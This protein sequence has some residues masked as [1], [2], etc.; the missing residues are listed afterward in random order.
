MKNLKYRFVIIILLIMTGSVAS[1]QSAK[2]TKLNPQD[3]PEGRRNFGM[4]ALTDGKVLVFGGD[5]GKGH[6][7]GDT[8]IYDLNKG[9]WEKLNC[10]LQPSPRKGIAMASVGLNKV[11][12]FGGS[13]N[14]LQFYDDTW[15]FDYDSLNWINLNPGNKPKARDGYAMS[16]YKDG[17][18]ALYGG[19]DTAQAFPQDTW[20]YSL[21]ANN[22][23]RLS[24]GFDVD[25]A[26]QLAKVTDGLLMQFSGY[27]C[28]INTLRKTWLFDTLQNKW[29]EIFPKNSPP[30]ITSG[31]V[32]QLEDGKVVLFGGHS[33]VD[34]DETWLFDIK[35]SSWTQILTSV[36][37]Q[38]RYL[39]RIAKIGEGKILLFSGFADW[40]LTNDTWL[41]S[42]E[43]AGVGENAENSEISI[44]PNP[45]SNFIEITYSPSNK[46][47]L[48]GV[49]EAARIYNVFGEEINLTPT[50]SSRG[51]GVRIDVSSLP[52]GLYF[53][54]VGDKIGKFVKLSIN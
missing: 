13:T 10:P 48:G 35:D 15:I 19:N 47:G 7:L 23:Q 1:A 5:D 20:I 18:I 38:G 3:S 6:V 17:M 24:F 41:L 25:N 51:E 36:K 4:A 42:F 43:P 28:C 21:A 37:P 29:K 12:M 30:P 50:L 2:W 11:I 49:L 16:P 34:V 54:R 46:R 9:N 44:S 22:W 33:D 14:D 52:T 32:E 27:S 8:W 53:V 31:S 39:H 26:A 40:P 45:A